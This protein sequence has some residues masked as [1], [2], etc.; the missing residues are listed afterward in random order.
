MP[1]FIAAL[2]MIAEGRKQSMCPL[3]DETDMQ[4]VVHP[5]KGILVSLKKEK[6]DT[7]VA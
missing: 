6:G 1:I 3:M 4:N 7:W 2:F 5:D